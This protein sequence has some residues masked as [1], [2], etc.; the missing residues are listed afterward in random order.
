MSLVAYRSVTADHTG[1]RAGER[2][3][4]VAWADENG[5]EVSIKPA[6][7]DHAE[8]MIFVGY[9]DGVAHWTL[10]RADGQ[11]WLCCVGDQT[12]QGREGWKAAVPS[13]EDALARIIADTKA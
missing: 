7:A 8:G 10:Y 3:R 4:L 1:F 13:V 6:D 11:L 5:L 2:A 9:G 12:A